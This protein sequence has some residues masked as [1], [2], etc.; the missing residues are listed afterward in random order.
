M[1]SKELNYTRTTS[2]FELAPQQI[3]S[4]T[5][6]KTVADFILSSRQSELLRHSSSGSIYTAKWVKVY[7]MEL[8]DLVD[9]FLILIIFYL[10]I[11]PKSII[12]KIS[13][14]IISF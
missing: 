14:K 13:G 6:T 2:L 4:S 9:Y 7:F 5:I 12:T 11:G 1:K 10:D 3:A 8:I